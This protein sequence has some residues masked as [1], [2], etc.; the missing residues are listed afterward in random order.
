MELRRLFDYSNRARKVL[1]KT[2]A[3]HP[4]VFDQ[5]FKTRADHASILKLLGHIV[6]AEERWIYGV[7]HNKRVIAYEKRL[8]IHATANRITHDVVFEDWAKIRAETLRVLDSLDAQHMQEPLPQA[9]GLTPEQIF[10][11]L[12]NHETHHRAQIS[13]ILQ[14]FDIEP[15]DFDFVFFLNDTAD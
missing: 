15:P 6:G 7:F 2:L 14:H 13:M 3:K 1:E 8:Q 11:H 5:P 9:R 4:D 12:I 10:F